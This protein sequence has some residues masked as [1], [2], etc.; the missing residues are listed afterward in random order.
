MIQLSEKPFTTPFDLEYKI[1]D[2]NNQIGS[3][4]FLYE[5]DKIVYIENFYLNKLYRNKGEGTKLA[6]IFI[7]RMNK[8]GI[9]NIGLTSVPEAIKFWQKLGF[10]LKNNETFMELELKAS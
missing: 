7:N 3:I 8:N 9:A 2:K 1:F 6:N 10:N 5:N 4:E